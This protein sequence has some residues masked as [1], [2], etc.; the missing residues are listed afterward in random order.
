MNEFLPSRRE[1][2]GVLQ[3]F[4]A[5]SLRMSGCL[6]FIHESALSLYFLWSQKRKRPGALDTV[7]RVRIHAIIF[8]EVSEF[9]NPIDLDILKQWGFRRYQDFSVSG[10]CFD[11]RMWLTRPAFNYGDDTIGDVRIELYWRTEPSRLCDDRR[12]L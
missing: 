7:D 5:S 8:N 1:D 6:S 12:M 4:F 2:A 3:V 11:R 10:R 9:Q